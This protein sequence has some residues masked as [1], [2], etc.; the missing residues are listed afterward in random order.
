[1]ISIY[2]ILIIIPFLLLSGWLSAVIAKGRK[3]T[4]W[5]AFLVGLCLGFPGLGII[6]LFLKSKGK[7]KKGSGR[8]ETI[9]IISIIALTIGGIIAKNVLEKKFDRTMEKYSYNTKLNGMGDLYNYSMYHNTLIRTV[10]VE[11]FAKKK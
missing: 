5:K 6:L 1:M 9:I 2:Q 7:Q 4:Q 11:E 8:V 10:S 3:R